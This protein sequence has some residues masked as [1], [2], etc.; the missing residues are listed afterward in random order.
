MGQGMAAC[1]DF[2]PRRVVDFTFVDALDGK[3][4]ERTL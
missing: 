4:R 2:A 3:M 1:L